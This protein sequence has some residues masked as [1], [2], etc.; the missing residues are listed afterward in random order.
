MYID[1]IDNIIY[2]IIILYK[3]IQKSINIFIYSIWESE[4]ND[5]YVFMRK[6]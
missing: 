6:L 5:I 3:I 1:N 2:Q 4:S